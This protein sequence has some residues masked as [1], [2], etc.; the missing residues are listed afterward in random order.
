MTPVTFSVRPQ[1]PVDELCEFLVRGRIHRA[2]VVED[3]ELVGI[4]TSQD[5]LKAVAEHRLEVE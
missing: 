4:I 1:M 2:L 5:V 3:D